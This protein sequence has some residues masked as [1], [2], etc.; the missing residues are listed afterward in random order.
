MRR[1]AVKNKD[2]TSKYNTVKCEVSLWKSVRTKT[3]KTRKWIGYGK[4]CNFWSCEHTVYCIIQYNSC[5]LSSPSS[6]PSMH[7]NLL[8]SVLYLPAS[9]CLSLLPPFGKPFCSSTNSFHF[10][11]PSFHVN[12][13]HI[14]KISGKIPQFFRIFCPLTSNI[15]PNAQYL[16]T[17]ILNVFCC[18]CCCLILFLV[19]S[20]CVLARYF[21]LFHFFLS[22][23]FSLHTLHRSAIIQHASL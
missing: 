19:C 4:H 8:C 7:S 18:C 12:I 1:C 17:F 14:K 5:P 22:N 16:L 6:L 2:Q 15:C 11:L 20:H 13:W 21:I 10:Y 3:G 9:V 23:L